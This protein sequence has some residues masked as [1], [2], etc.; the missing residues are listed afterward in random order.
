MFDN[1]VLKSLQYFPPKFEVS[2][3]KFCLSKLVVLSR[4]L[5]KATQLDRLFGPAW[6]AYGHSFAL[7]N[8][9]DQAMAAYFKVIY[10]YMYFFSSLA[11]LFSLGTFIW[12]EFEVRIASMYYEGICA[13]LQKLIKSVCVCI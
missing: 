3:A 9:H 1:I 6:L 12:C 4:Y 10:I 8:E 13:C 5:N 7:E 2:S 11:I